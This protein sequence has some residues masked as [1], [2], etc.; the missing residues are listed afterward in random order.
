MFKF[1]HSYIKEY[2]VPIKQH[3]LV[4]SI[5]HKAA[6]GPSNGRFWKLRHGGFA[7]TAHQNIITSS[8]HMEK[9]LRAVYT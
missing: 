8:Y 6:C 2:C 7:L 4:R 1:P 3:C 5:E 9:C